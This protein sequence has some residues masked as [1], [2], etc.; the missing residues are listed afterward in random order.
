MAE[1]VDEI[2]MVGQEFIFRMVIALPCFR[3]VQWV[4]VGDGLRFI[5]K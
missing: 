5:P 3:P 2:I 1:K 4:R